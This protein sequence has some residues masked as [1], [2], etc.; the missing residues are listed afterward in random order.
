VQ[1][2][3]NKINI[4]LALIIHFKINYKSSTTPLKFNILSPFCWVMSQFDWPITKEK[5]GNIEGSPN[6]SFYFEDK[7]IK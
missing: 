5:H 4:G 7:N 2:W 3:G 1:D 6:R